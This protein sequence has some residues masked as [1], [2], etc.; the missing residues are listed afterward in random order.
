MRKDGWSL[1]E[2]VVLS[3]PRSGR[4]Q[5]S[6]VVVG[7]PLEVQC[8]RLALSELQTQIRSL[9]GELRSHKAEGLG[10]IALALAGLCPTKPRPSEVGLE[11]VDGWVPPE[12]EFCQ[13]GRTEG[14]CNK[15][16]VIMDS[17]G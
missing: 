3:L 1:L 13:V 5:L 15:E 12:L 2:R 14:I 11:R 7:K 4:N 6:R 8:L 10:I 17:E 16:T 9:V